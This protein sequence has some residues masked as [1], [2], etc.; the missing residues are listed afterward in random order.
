MTKPLTDEEFEGLKKYYNDSLCAEIDSKINIEARYSGIKKERDELKRKVEE[1]ETRKSGLL[2]NWERFN[3]LTQELKRKVDE[4]EKII[5]IDRWI[6]DGMPEE[7]ME[8]KLLGLK[9]EI[10]NLESCTELKPD[11]FALIATV[12]QLKKEEDRLNNYNTILKE[13]IK[14]LHWFK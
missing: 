1:L 3:K 8:R 2:A 12:D 9:L 10:K 14:T 13:E 7:Q 5:E 11:V 6:D 4:L